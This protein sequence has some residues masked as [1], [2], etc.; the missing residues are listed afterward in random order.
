LPTRWCE[1]PESSHQRNSGGKG[2]ER[3]RTHRMRR[4]GFQP[5]DKTVS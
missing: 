1:R 3:Q 5:L 4:I 2:T